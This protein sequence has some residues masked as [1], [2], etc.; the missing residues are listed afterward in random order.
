M[1][2]PLCETKRCGRQA[3]ALWGLVFA[4][5][6]S[7]TVV[8]AVGKWEA[9]W[10]CGVSEGVWELVKTWLGGVKYFV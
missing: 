10:F 8:G 7:E 2:C 3:A 5:E 4:L 9:R 1:I 6:T